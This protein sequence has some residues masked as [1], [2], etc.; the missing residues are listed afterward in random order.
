MD[1]RVAKIR[2]PT[3]QWGLKEGEAALDVVK[4]Y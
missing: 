3:G 1:S 4:K 2:K